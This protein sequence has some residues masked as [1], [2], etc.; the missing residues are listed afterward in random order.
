MKTKRLLRILSLF[1]FL[2]L[3]APFYDACDGKSLF[4]KVPE[5]EIAVNKPFKEKAYDVIVNENA[6]NAYD[7]AAPIVTTPL[8]ETKAE[9]IEIAN[10]DD[11]Y[12][13]LS[14]VISLI[15][16]CII[17]ISLSLLIV[18]FFNKQKLFV[19]LALVN[20]I[21]VVTTFLYIIVLE[22]SFDHWRQIKWGYYAF[23]M[24]SLLIFYYSRV[25][26]KRQNP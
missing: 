14:V 5:S 26:L 16:G 9:L 8:K 6:F 3:F 17:I 25:T 4:K 7:I 22:S 2:L 1:G 12:H 20:C 13:N 21:L 23:I 19:K 11:W 15:F 24:V 10:K 18:S